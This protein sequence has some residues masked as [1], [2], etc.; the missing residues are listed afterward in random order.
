MPCDTELEEA[1]DGGLCT[2]HPCI[3]SCGSE[4]ERVRCCLGADGRAGTDFEAIRLDSGA[5][6]AAEPLQLRT[7]VCLAQAYALG[8]ARG[9]ACTVE[10]VC[11]PSGL[12]YEVRRIPEDLCAPPRG[13]TAV[14]LDAETGELLQVGLD[15]YSG[16]CP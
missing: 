10:T 3:A 5:C 16:P 1:P 2:T 4:A 12:V 8:R 9:E 14:A 13:I 6:P 15:T 11:A 7:A